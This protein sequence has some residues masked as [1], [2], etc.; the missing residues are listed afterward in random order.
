MTRR[1]NF[2]TTRQLPS[3]RWQARYFEDGEQIPLGETFASEREASTALAKVEADL[4]RGTHVNP[5]LAEG[6]L[7]DFGKEYMATKTDWAPNTRQDR[8]YLWR[9]Y[10]EPAFGKMTFKQLASSSSKIR[11]WHA[12]LHKKHPATAAGAYKLLR[13]ICRAAVEDH[14]MAQNPCKVKG[15]TVDRAQERKIAT[16]AEVEAIYQ[17]MPERMRAWI[18]LAMYAG[19]RRSEALGLRR[20]DLDLAHNTVTVAQ[21]R[22]YLRTGEWYVGAGKSPAARRTVY[23]PS[24]IAADL[25]DHLARFVAPDR[26][27]LVFTNDDGGPLRPDQFGWEFRK[28][29]LAAD[30]PNLT[31]HDLRH[32][33]DTLAA[34]TGA[35]LPEL[36]Y[37][38][39][40][41]TERMALR[42]L[43][44]TRDRDRVIGEALAGLRPNAPVIPIRAATERD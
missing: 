15:A 5:R 44:A 4:E 12:G 10:V 11:S 16:V 20:C 34:A 36:M 35:T 33:A 3:G 23:F 14:R 32:T 24:S 2:G 6:L 40:H 37:R 31:L 41:A 17:A 19:L 8:E 42:Y 28:A 18:L 9:R 22:H 7:G 21:T 39:G 25:D 43:H 13:Q 26:E 27:S 1:R 30:R 29:R 38:M